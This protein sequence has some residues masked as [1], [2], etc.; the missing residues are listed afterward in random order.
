MPD[1]KRFYD[2]PSLDR[3]TTRV[4][5]AGSVDGRPWVRLD[6]TIFY[7]EGGGQPSDRGRIGEAVVV[8][9]VSRG[10][11]VLHV[12]DREIRSGEVV[13][14]LDAERRF[15]HCQQHT[16]Q[17]LLTAVLVD[18]HGM[19]TT[20]F[21][22]GADYT[23]I[24]V[25]GAV[26]SWEAL[27]RFEREVNAHLRED[28]EVSA[29]WVAP[30]E[31]PALNVRSRGLPEGHTGPV[32]LVSIEGLDLNTCG[33][34][35]VARLGE[36][37]A[38]E[39]IDAEPARGGARIRF[40]AGG[41]V[42]VDLDRRRR[43]E[44]ALKARIGTAPGEFAAVIDGWAAER[45]ALERRV[46]TLTG[47]L[48]EALAVTLASTPGPLVCAIRPGAGPE[49]LKTLASAI[50]ARRPEAVVALA[51]DSGEP[52]GACFLVQAGPRGP[53]DVQAA[54]GRVRELMGAKGGG[55][56]STFQG[57]GGT[58]PTQDA[59]EKAMGLTP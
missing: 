30:E 21:H 6:E 44:E 31:L 28:R 56:G 45:K 57:K 27:A 42:L 29:R 2:D 5:E 32:R 24:E 54:G 25:Q 14:V 12:L 20:S 52:G 49:A 59:L 40:L 1:T 43:V 8:E 26:P 55:K 37:Q 53:S 22:L 15:D 36:L 4:V 7:P 18:R 10:E 35:H 9:V 34:T 39:L 46:K 47:E 51:G 50:L 58:L 17:H 3:L 11:Q 41:R 23:S 13:T 48:A 19:P 33:G 38:I 16:A